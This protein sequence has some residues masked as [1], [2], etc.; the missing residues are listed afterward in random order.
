MDWYDAR[1]YCKEEDARLA[2]FKSEFEYEQFILLRPYRDEWIEMRFESNDEN[3]NPA[4]WWNSDGS[5]PFLNWKEGQPDNDG[6]NEKCATVM[7]K[8]WSHLEMHDKPCTN[9]YYFTCRKK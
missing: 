2:F 1:N 5:S 6:E 8:E 4:A 3:E 9:Q 7:R